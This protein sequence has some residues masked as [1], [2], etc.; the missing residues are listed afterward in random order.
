MVGDWQWYEVVQVT[1]GILIALYV[2]CLYKYRYQFNQI[3]RAR[4]HFVFGMRDRVYQRDELFFFIN[5]LMIVMKKR[6]L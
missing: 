2:N 6:K 1:V 4:F 5:I 3:N